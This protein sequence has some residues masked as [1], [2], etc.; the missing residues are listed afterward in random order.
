MTSPNAAYVHVP[1]CIHRCGYCDFTVIAD[2]DD[3]IETYLNCLQQEL[4]VA[5]AQLQSTRLDTLFIGGGTPSYLPAVSLKQFFDM[6]S[7]SLPL[8]PQA[9]FSIECNPEEFTSDRMDV[10]AEAGVN[11]VSLG[12]QSF[13]PQHLLTLERRHSPADIAEVM[14]RLRDRRLNNISLDLIFAIPGQSLS[15]WKQTLQHAID[16]QPT[17]VSTYGLTFEKGTA[18]WTRRNKQLLKP[19]DEELERAMYQYAMEFLP[20]HGYQ[21]YELSNFAKP[22]FECQHNRVYWDAAEYFGFGPGAASYLNGIRACNHRSVRTWIKRIQSKSSPIGEQEELSAE[23]R[24]REAV[25]LGLRQI[26]GIDLAAYAAQHE[27]TVRSLN[28]AAFDRC[29]S[30]DLLKIVS[31]SFTTHFRGS[32]YR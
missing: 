1:F 12:V 19:A 2:R 9:E 20:D 22:G 29:L 3:L 8:A 24:A 5:R 13:Q 15:E 21:Q 32:F 30:G 31:R 26:S 10:V 14:Q 17:H 7:A 28:P 25:M 16:L 4:K 23:L 6:L 11:R 18:F 27:R